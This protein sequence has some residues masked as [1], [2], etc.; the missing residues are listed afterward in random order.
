MFIS[1]G[2]PNQQATGCPEAGMLLVP[3]KES[4]HSVGTQLTPWA[5][6]QGSGKGSWITRQV[7]VDVC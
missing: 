3:P 4:G 7:V 6:G 2:C 5:K 1:H